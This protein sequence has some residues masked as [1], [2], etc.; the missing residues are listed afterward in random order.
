MNMQPYNPELENMVSQTEDDSRGDDIG[1]AIFDMDI[2]AATSRYTREMNKPINSL[3]LKYCAD[4]D[5]YISPNVEFE[6]YARLQV[7]MDGMLFASTDKRP[8]KYCG[9]LVFGDTCGSRMQPKCE[10]QSIA[11]TAYH[12]QARQNMLDQARMQM[13]NELPF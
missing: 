10:K 1:F 8:C 11:N 3:N 6:D 2:D 5:F 12:E 4:I 7:E 9:K 13:L